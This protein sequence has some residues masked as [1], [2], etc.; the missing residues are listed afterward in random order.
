MIYVAKITDFN[1]LDGLNLLT[2]ERM[3]KVSE[4]AHVD[5]KKRCLVGGLLLRYSLK[6]KQNDIFYNEYGKPLVDGL[7]FNLS[8]SGEYVVLAVDK[9]EI[10]VD[11]EK[12][13]PSKRYSVQNRFC[14][15]ELALLQNSNSNRIFYQLWTGK[16]SY[17]KAIGKGLSVALN[18]FSVLPIK[19]GERA[20]FN[21]KVGLFWY[22]LSGYQ[23][24]VC[25]KTRTKPSLIELTIDDLLK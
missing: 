12:I 14:K 22:D 11:I 8:H 19:D 16:E 20:I 4:F 6:E 18:G 23:L 17:L 10:G 5:D 15:E 21:E 24:C 2:K 9:D 3:E 25:A 1:N 13:S 7:F